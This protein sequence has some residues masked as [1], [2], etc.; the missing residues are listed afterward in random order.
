MPSSSFI[1]KPFFSRFGFHYHALLFVPPTHLLS[2]AILNAHTHVHTTGT[3]PKERNTHRSHE[4]CNLRLQRNRERSNRLFRERQIYSL[5]NCGRTQVGYRCAARLFPLHASLHPS[6]GLSHDVSPVVWTW[7]CRVLDS[8]WVGGTKWECM[9]I[10]IQVEKLVKHR[11]TADCNI[12]GFCAYFFLLW[13]T[14]YWMPVI[15]FNQTKERERE[16]GKAITLLMYKYVY[17]SK[18]LNKPV[19]KKF[20]FWSQCLCAQHHIIFGREDER[21]KKKYKNLHFPEPASNVA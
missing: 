12:H 14:S 20:H 10:E 18:W 11:G 15:V 19:K 2:L 13:R 6:E 7:V 8:T 17:V 4:Y 16:G 21:R 3:P 1:H 9:I 5:S